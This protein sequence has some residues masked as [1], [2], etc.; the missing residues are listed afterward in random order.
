[1]EFPQHATDSTEELVKRSNDLFAS[2]RRYGWPSR[3]DYIHGQAYLGWVLTFTINGR[4]HELRFQAQVMDWRFDLNSVEWPA[5][6]QG[7]SE[8]A[9]GHTDDE[10]LVLIDDVSF[11]QAPEGIIPSRIRVKVAAE[12]HDFVTSVFCPI[13]DDGINVV[14]EFGEREIRLI[15]ALASGCCI[16]ADHEVKRGPQIMDCVTK[17]ARYFKWGRF[18][19]VDVES[20][21]PRLRV[22]L[23]PDMVW[24]S[25]EE[26]VDEKVHLSDVKL[27]PL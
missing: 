26:A 15:D 7:V 9:E 18:L 20:R 8:I 16:G 11:V 3:K 4:W 21:L 22:D 25:A 14:S 19:D 1:M 17:D 10:R 13:L 23:L 12:L 2:Q 24:M 6:Q 27:R 5:W